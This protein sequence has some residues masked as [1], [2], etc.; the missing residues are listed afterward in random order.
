MVSHSLAP[1][2]R[3]DVE[4]AVVPAATVMTGWRVSTWNTSV[5]ATYFVTAVNGLPCSG[6]S[7]VIQYL[8]VKPIQPSVA[9]STISACAPSRSITGSSVMALYFVSVNVPSTRPTTP[10]CSTKKFCRSA[11]MPCLATMP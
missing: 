6:I 9:A 3:R 4:D 7:V 8:S 5:A 1:A 10:S 11:G 2:N